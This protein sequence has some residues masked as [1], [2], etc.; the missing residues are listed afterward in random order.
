MSGRFTPAALTAMA[1][2]PEP[3]VGL[4]IRT[5][6]SASAA[7]LPPFTAMAVM[8]V[9]LMPAFPYSY[10]LEARGQITPR[11]ATGKGRAIHDR[12]TGGGP[13]PARPGADRGGARRPRTLR[14]RGAGGTHRRSGERN[15]PLPRPD[16]QEGGHPGRRR[17]PVLPARL[18]QV[19]EPTPAFD[20]STA[21]GRR[22][23]V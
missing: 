11:G 2:S 17:R 20:L 15:R 6:S 22:R 4:S 18:T 13:A 5:A 16:R 10:A 1:I 7:P 23:A 14:G 3:G 21:A 9:S 19:T 8:V 12:R